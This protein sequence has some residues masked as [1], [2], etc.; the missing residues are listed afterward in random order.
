M[1][2][3][4]NIKTLLTALQ[5]VLVFVVALFI[6]LGVNGWVSARLVAALPPAM[7]PPASAAALSP[8]EAAAEQQESALLYNRNLFSLIEDE[9]PPDD[10]ILGPNGDGSDPIEEEVVDPDAPKESNLPLELLGT[11][12]S[13]E[14]QWSV[15]HLRQT[16]T[17]EDLYAHVGDGV[18]GATL[19]AIHRTFVLVRSADGTIESITLGGQSA[20]TGNVVTSAK[21]P[22][23]QARGGS[24]S[25]PSAVGRGALKPIGTTPF[26]RVDDSMVNAGTQEGMFVVNRDVAK[27]QAE[28]VGKLADGMGL[29]EQ[30]DNG[31]KLGFRVGSIAPG[32][33]FEKVGIQGGDII[34]SVD[35]ARPE[36]KEQAVGFVSDL[37]REGEVIVEIDRR[38]ERRKVKLQTK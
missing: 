4:R 30:L 27:T 17:R 20:S 16:G 33:L 7:V 10:L 34:V 36:T 3:K 28:F 37:A 22:A 38:G 24:G 8:E 23:F 2:S 14:A 15:A 12:V 29:A 1:K 35:G 18:E 25:S 5:L 19:I 31:E 9:T 13:T 26:I 21:A 11:M 32:S 6:A